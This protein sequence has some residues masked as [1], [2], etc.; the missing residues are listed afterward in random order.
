MQGSPP[1]SGSSR[2]T[3][4][5]ER[6]RHYLDL[7]LE[8]I[9]EAPVSLCV[10]CDREPGK[11]I[12]GRH[13]IPDTDLYSTC[14]AIEN[15][16]LAARAEGVGIGW[17]SFYREDDVRE[18]LGIPPHVVPVAWLCV[19]Y[20]DERPSRPGLEAAGWGRRHRSHGTCFH[21]RW[22][23]AA[24][25]DAVRPPADAGRPARHRPR[26]R[27]WW[28]ALAD[29]GRARRPGGRHPRPRRLRRARQAGRQP[30]RAR[31]AARTL[32]GRD[33]RPA[34]RQALGRGS[35]CSPPT[36]ASRRAASASTPAASA[37]RS[38]RPPPAAR[39]RSACSRAALGAELVVAI[40]GLRGR[41]LAGVR[42][43]PRRRR[44]RRHRSRPG[45]DRRTAARSDRRRPRARRRA[46]RAA[47]S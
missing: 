23:D 43:L 3:H 5:D 21:E 42:D 27:T 36:T 46:R 8:G 47:T 15:L 31:D 26:S 33:R 29:R 13:T 14:L 44:K 45:D 7:K 34:E 37:P 2:P 4:L 19:G 9:R 35:S 30:R 11:E 18:L 1:A 25:A 41:R 40:V 38:R 20:P 17:V 32:G 12:L 6:A 28:R 16:W 39:R 24:G 10:C 22:G